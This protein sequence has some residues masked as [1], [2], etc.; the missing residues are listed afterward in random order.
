MNIKK[1]LVASV[2]GVSCLNISAADCT[3]DQ[4]KASVEKMC[5]L[6]AEKGKAA[7]PEVAKYRF[8]GSNYVWIQDK[9]VNM[10]LHPIKRRLNGKSLKSN[11]DENG[12]VLFVEFDK[13]AN[14]NAEGGWVDYVW[15]KPGA[16]KATPKVSYIKKCGGDTGWIAGAGIW[17]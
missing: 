10:V 6:I 5:A 14:A 16:E 8:C 13:A 3:K 7:I 2:L 17:K 15:A 1:M 11:K 4:A 9:D 12:K